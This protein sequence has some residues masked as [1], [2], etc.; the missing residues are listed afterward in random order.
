MKKTAVYS[1]AA[2]FLFFIVLSGIAYAQGGKGGAGWGAGSSYNRLYNPKTV[3]TLSGEVA[4]I[5]M[6]T[7]RK[8]M[9]QGIHLVLKTD[10]ETI[11]VH[12]GP[13]WYMDKQ[14]VKIEQGDKIEVTGSRITY[15]GK[16]AILASEVKKGDKTIQL[17][18]ANGIPAWSRRS[19]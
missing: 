17:R 16:P 6:F 15:N 2:L 11:P 13:S 4:K 8:G 7:P 10:K 19:R 3:E 14:N 12:L 5:E 9:G 1:V 18:G